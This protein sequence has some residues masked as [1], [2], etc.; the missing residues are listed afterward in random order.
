MTRSC[1]ENVAEIK[2]NVLLNPKRWGDRYPTG[3]LIAHKLH[4]SVLFFVFLI[5]GEEIKNVLPKTGLMGH[6]TNFRQMFKKTTTQTVS[7]L[8]FAIL[9]FKLWPKGVF[10][11][12]NQLQRYIFKKKQHGAD[13]CCW[14]KN[15]AYYKFVWKNILMTKSACFGFLFSFVR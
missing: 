11:L 10:S 15:V 6:I 5:C 14:R 1:R 2:K 13:V 4:W 9:P 3:S 8:F 7:S 12:I